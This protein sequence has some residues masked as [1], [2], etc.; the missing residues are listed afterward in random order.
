MKKLLLI[1]F[2]VGFL[3]IIVSSS[4]STIFLGRTSLFNNSF[5]VAISSNTD[6]K[7]NEIIPN[8]NGDDNAPMPNGEWVE[9]YN[10]GSS[11]IDVNGWRLYDAIDS[12]ELDITAANVLGGSTIIPTHGFL[13]VYRNCDSDFSLNNDSSGD[14]VRL[15]D[16][17]ISVGNLIDSYNYTNPNAS[18]VFARIPDGNGLWVASSTQTPG[19]PNV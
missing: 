13:V 15:Y 10:S 4:T 2:S 8:P 14:T 17:L 11:P 7:L 3:A 19:G 18:W 6:I 1:I 9:L 5:S 16:G 12:H